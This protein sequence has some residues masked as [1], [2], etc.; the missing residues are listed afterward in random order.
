MIQ[1][2]K[3]LASEWHLVSSCPVEKISKYLAK[4]G[5]SSELRKELKGSKV[6]VGKVVC[7]LNGDKVT[8]VTKSRSSEKRKTLERDQARAAKQQMRFAS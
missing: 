2:K 8:V 6:K 7:V 3:N 5:V 4:H 1:K